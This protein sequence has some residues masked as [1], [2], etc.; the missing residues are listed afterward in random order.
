M[1]VI[2]SIVCF[3][4]PVKYSTLYQRA[5]NLYQ[6]AVD[7]I[8]NHG[9][10]RNG[11]RTRAFWS[12]VRD[13]DLFWGGNNSALGED[14]LRKNAGSLTEEE[15]IETINEKI[16][17]SRREHTQKCKSN[18]QEEPDSEAYRLNRHKFHKVNNL[19]WYEGIAYNQEQAAKVLWRENN[20]NYIQRPP[21]GFSCGQPNSIPFIETIS[22]SLVNELYSLTEDQMKFLEALSI[23]INDGK[24]NAKYSFSEK[25]STPDFRGMDAAKVSLQNVIR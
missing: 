15:Q 2:S 11:G 18:F 24:M 16:A 25:S 12:G 5:Q 22:F 4:N 10:K 19:A 14:D 1:L 9:E 21:F 23:T 20:H 17:V 7:T 3:F 8:N 6:S 13:P